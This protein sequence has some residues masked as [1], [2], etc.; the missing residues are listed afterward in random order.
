MKKS[1]IILTFL[2]MQ[3]CVFAQTSNGWINQGAEFYHSYN[4]NNEYGYVRYYLSE[5]FEVNG[6]MLQRL[7]GEKKYRYLTGPDEW[8]ENDE[9]IEIESKLFHTSNDTVYFA[10]SNGDLRFA[11]HLNPQVGDI[12]DFGL[13][14]LYSSDNSIHAYA[15]VE[16]IDVIEINGVQ[17]IDINIT[18][19]IDEQC[20]L[21]AGHEEPE[22][23]YLFCFYQ[24]KINSLYGPYT[25]FRFMGFY[26]INL[27]FNYCPSGFSNL[28]CY[29]S[30]DTDLI[31]WYPQQGCSNGVSSIQDYEAQTFTLFPNPAKEQIHFSGLAPNQNVVVYSNLGQV[32]FTVQGKQAKTADVSHLAKGLYFYRIVDEVNNKIYSGKFVKD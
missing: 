14:P 18:T 4:D 27:E 3:L 7:N 23:P 8:V 11:W 29:S 5:E 30:D 10:N 6:R 16:S 22:D 19:C 17:S 20:L 2:S 24:G 26:E 9:I 1:S 28:T 15:I 25:N 13:Y 32:L 12:W 21:L 31:E